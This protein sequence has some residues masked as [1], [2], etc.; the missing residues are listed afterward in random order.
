MVS[1][2]NFKQKKTLALELVQIAAGWRIA[3]H[4]LQPEMR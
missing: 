1:F 2:M 3:A 4:A